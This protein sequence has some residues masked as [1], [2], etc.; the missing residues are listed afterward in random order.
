[1]AIPGFTAATGLYRPSGQYRMTQ[2]TRSSRSIL[3]PAQFWVSRPSGLLRTTVD[4]AIYYDE[5]SLPILRRPGLGAPEPWECPWVFIPVGPCG[6][7]YCPVARHPVT[8][9]PIQQLVEAP[10]SDEPDL[11]GR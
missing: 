5:P 9:A 6:Y 1:M 3:H 10:C 4:G 8:G 2:T 11:W 7:Y